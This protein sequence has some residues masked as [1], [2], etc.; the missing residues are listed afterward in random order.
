MST[1]SDRRT[2][3]E[4][5]SQV[6]RELAR[7]S[8]AGTDA[9]GFAVLMRALAASA[10]SAGAAAVTSGRWLVDIA[11]D[12]AGHL[13]V[14]SRSVLDA[15]FPGLNADQIADELTAQAAKATAAVGAVAGGLAAAEWF[16]PPTWFAAPFELVTETLA[17]AAIEMRLIGELHAV[18]GRPIPS[19]KAARAGALAHAWANGSAVPAEYS[20]SGPTPSALWAAAG[21]K[22]MQRT[23]RS[24]LAKRA[25]R[26]AASFLPFLVG[27]AAGAKLNQSATS[28]LSNAVQR[29]LRTEKAPPLRR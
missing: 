12:L 8:A 17:V 1:E 20:E 26:N 21:K 18:Y 11:I 9:K 25:G 6:G 4:R 27:A 7:V 14:R 28:K 13:P 3:T 10:R 23:L 19:E 5:D 22:Q 16:A 2:G 24:R 15:E 29:A